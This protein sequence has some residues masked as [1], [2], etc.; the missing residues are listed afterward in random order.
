M[1]T[2]QVRL[3][4]GEVVPMSHP[5]DWS[6]EQ[7]ESAI[8]ENFPDEGG[9]N[10]SEIPPT[11]F[12]EN[13]NDK[14]MELELSKA[15]EPKERLGWKGLKDDVIESLGNALKGGIGF[16]GNIPDNLEKSGKYIEENPGSSILHNA[17]Q[18]SAGTADIGKSIF[19][20]PH[21]L[22]QYLAKKEILPEWAGKA[23]KLIPHIPEDTGLEKALGLE[24]DPEKGDALI[25][26]IPEIASIVA[27]GVGLAKAGKRV[28]TAP[29]KE[30]LFQ[31][32]LEKKIAT[33]EKEHA[34]SKGDL[35]SLKESL[36]REYSSIHKQ[37]VGEMT[38]IGQ[39][40]N[41]NIKKGK[42]EELKPLTEIPEKQVGELPPE[43]DT[44]AIIQEKK[45]AAETARKE[46]EEA[47][48]VLDHPRLKGGAIIQ[49]AIKDVKQSSSDLYDSARKHYTDKKILADNSK[50][51]KSVTADLEALKAADDLA[52]GYGSGTAEQKALE[53]QLNALKGE[54]VNASDIFDLQRTLEKMAK[55]TRTKQYSG[56][57][58]LDFKRLGNLAERFDNHAD[59]LATR[60]ESVGGKEVQGMIKEAN[61]GWK[62]Y[63][64]L[65]KN[66]VGK[67][68]LSKGEIPSRAMIDIANT[69]K[70]NEFLQ[71]LTETYP[72][73]KKHMLAAHIGEGSVNK[74]LKPTSLTKKYLEALP[75]VEEKVQDLKQAIAGIKEGENTARG[76]KKEYDALVTSMKDAAKEQKVRQDAIKESDTLKK[77]IKFHED[78][79]PKLE[80]KIKA[81]EK[82]GE[83]H[84]KLS[85]E[86]KEHKQKLQDKN[87]LLKK[88]GDIVLKAT[89]VSS[90]MGKFG[91]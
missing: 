14:P 40:E 46:A 17:G 58:E 30:T 81:A 75:E 91:L 42:L 41:I 38:P 2:I 68:A 7:V 48:G 11:P 67:A 60:L 9:G 57:S 88:Y 54:Q 21:D 44:R 66:N 13:P 59:K 1:A 63:K 82:K 28:L 89:G 56:V 37:K 15:A 90:L 65:E 39:E 33:A 53:S 84:V 31:R 70:G 5:D 4:S 3:K 55:D 19:N 45:T 29:S 87:H 47:L 64:E 77:Q 22:N 83:E 43:P 69:Q 27:P 85:N 10:E 32:A 78:A 20:A 61:K 79:I 6:P 16:L 25:R 36:R 73:L 18:L 51:I 76:V 62:T 71:A 72:E 35:D 49:K 50:E 26:A 34:L 52:P 24:A 80:A 74:L 8:H 86:L 12:N 23:G